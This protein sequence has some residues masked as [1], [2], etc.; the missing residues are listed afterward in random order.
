MDEKAVFEERLERKQE[1]GSDIFKLLAEMIFDAAEGEFEIGKNE[2]AR[3]AMDDGEQNNKA[4]GATN[5]VPV[6]RENERFADFSLVVPELHREALHGAG[7]ALGGGVAGRIATGEGD[8]CEAGSIHE[9]NLLDLEAAGFLEEDVFISATRK[10]GL[11]MPEKAVGD[12]W[13]M[14][15]SGT[16]RVF[17]ERPPDGGAE[18]RLQVGV[19]AVFFGIYSTA[20]GLLDDR[21]ESFA[22]VVIGEIGARVSDRMRDFDNSRGLEN[23]GGCEIGNSPGFKWSGRGTW[24]WS[25][26]SHWSNG[27][28]E[29]RER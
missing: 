17:G 4:A 19:D 12:G 7:D 20:D 13:R 1:L 16:R 9:E 26:G 15:R 2:F 11:Q 10:K 25:D 22:E 8:E 6:I 24:Q 21:S 3:A 5:G 29:C 23:R 27:R 28:W 18:H 14:E